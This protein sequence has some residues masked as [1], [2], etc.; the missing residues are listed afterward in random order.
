MTATVRV[1]Q[2]RYSGSAVQKLTCAEGGGIL[3]NMNAG[4]CRFKGEAVFVDIPGRGN[5]VLLMETPDFGPTPYPFR[6]YRERHSLFGAWKLGPESM[7]WMVTF[8][9]PTNPFS[10]KTVDPEHLDAAFGHDVALDSVT[11]ENT[12]APTT[13]GRLV[14]YLPWVNQ[15]K[16]TL[17]DGSMGSLSNNP[18]N[19]IHFHDLIGG[20]N[21][22]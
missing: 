3:G 9:D 14:K 20:K 1:G 16:D 6:I 11:A 5:L 7:P 21:S 2:A 8:K 13:R 18:A 19:R 17:L 10:I 4:W 15:S 12:W 22:G